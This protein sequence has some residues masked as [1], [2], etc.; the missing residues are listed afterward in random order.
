MALE[1][2]QD[3]QNAGQ[4]TQ[5]SDLVSAPDTTTM[6]I[7]NTA[8][9]DVLA[10]HA[11]M[12][13]EP[14]A[15]V[16]NYN[17]MKGE[18]AQNQGSTTYDNIMAAGNQYEDDASSRAMADILGDATVPLDQKVGYA[19][20]WK[21]GT[22]QP[23]GQDRKPSELVGINQLAKDSTV[24]DNAE[25]D[26]TRWDLA[27]YLKQV[28]DYNLEVNKIMN[29][30][31]LQ[32]NHGLV[33]KG[34]DLLESMVPFVS[35]A[36]QALIQTTLRKKLGQG[37]DANGLASGVAGS[38]TL[39]GESRQE[40][41]D[42]IAKLPYDKRLDMAKTVSDAVIAHNGSI[43]DD[44]NPMMAMNS[45][46]DYM[47]DGQYSTSD[48]VV[49][50]ATSLLDLLGV[51][52]VLRNLKRAPEL[53]SAAEA[54]RVTGRNPMTVGETVANTNA[55][56]ANEIIG[57]A[58][59]DTTGQV[60]KA[61]Y[62]TDRNSAIVNT[63]GPEIGNAQ[64]IVRQK[65]LIDDEHF[66]PDY[67]A[68]DT[69]LSNNGAIQFSDAEKQSKVAVVTNDF[70]NP[71]VTGLTN[72]KEMTTIK[73][74]DDGV[75]VRTVFAPDDGGFSNP[76]EALNQVKY[77]TRK[78]GVSDDELT[79]YKRDTD[80]Q[81]K[82]VDKSSIPQSDDI[83]TP[84]PVPKDHTRM[85]TGGS[86]K[87][88]D[89][90]LTY[91]TDLNKATTDAAAVDGGKVRYV[92]VPSSHPVFDNSTSTNQKGVELGADISYNRK[93]L[94]TGNYVVGVNHTTPFDPSDTINWSTTDV[95]GKFFGVP[96]NLFDK[97]PYY[98][99]G[100]GGSITQHL[101]PPQS[102]ID[103]LLARS[104]SVTSD[105]IAHSNNVL[106]HSANEY[107]TNYK[108][109]DRV[110]QKQIDNYILK[111][112]HDSIKF[113]PQQLKADGFSDDA[114]Q[115]LR[116]WKKT[117][118][119]Q[120]VLEN[121]DMG[122]QAK[123]KG[124]QMLQTV[125]GQDSLLV[126]PLSNST[127][128]N[129]GVTKAYDPELGVI[130]DIT[131][132]ERTELYKAG[133]NISMAR[134]PV[135]VKDQSI[136][137][138]IVKNNSSVYTRGLR[139]SD[140]L[141]NY[142]DG[143][144]TIYY[145]DPIFV[146]KIVKNADGSEYTR[147]VATV[148]N[149]KDA[150]SHLARLK[151]TDPEGKYDI[152]ADRV[153]EELNELLWNSRVNAGRTAQRTRGEMLEDVSGNPADVNFAH[154]A[155]PEESLLRSINSIS[156]RIN[157]KEW[158]DVTKK[159]FM[160]QYDDFIP[161]SADHAPIWPDDVT[162]LVKPNSITGDMRSYTDAVS[163]YRYVDQ[164]ENGFVNL[165]DDASKNLFKA[166]GDTVGK[167]GFK[168]MEGL[169]RGA[170]DI[171]PSAFLRKKAF[172]LLL[173]ANP[174]RQGVVQFSQAIPVI[175]ATNPTYFAK[176]P[177]QMLM[178]RYLDRGG[179][180]NSFMKTIGHSLAGFNED[181]ARQLTKAYQDSGI[182]SAV[183]AHSLIRDDLRSLVNR[184]PAA[185]IA[186]VAAKPIDVMQKVGF[187]AGENM[188]MR[189]VWLS[190]YDNLRKSGKAINNESLNLLHARVRD[191][192]LNMN[193]AGELAYNENMLSPIM[194][195]AQAPHK[196]FAQI[197]AGNRSL[198][199]MDRLK[200]GTSYVVTYGT[201]YGAIYSLSDS[202]LPRDDTDLHNIVSGGLANLALNKT[203]S[204][205]FGQKS[206]TDFSSS[207]RL[208]PLPNIGD[209]WTAM[210]T[211]DLQSMITGS[212]SLSMVVG[213]NGKVGNLLKSMYR[214]YTVPTD[215]G[216]LK[217]VG[218]N[219]LS[220]FSGASNMFKARYAFERGY[221]TTTKGQTSDP[222]VSEVE[223]MNMALG[224]NTTDDMLKY[225]LNDVQYAKSAQIRQ[226]AKYLIDE[227]AK[228]LGREGISDKEVEYVLRMYQEA[229]RVYS[230]SPA[231]LQVVQD[232][233]G[234]R[235]KNGDYTV[236]NSL[237]KNAGLYTEQEMRDAVGKSPL[238]EDQ[239]KGFWKIFDVMKAP[240]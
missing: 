51:G 124:F 171:K 45:L 140:K 221:S 165:L 61:V 217:D 191:L 9:A 39:L 112:N 151:T 216:A 163:T 10:S 14:Q 36:N 102:Y 103:P 145:K 27:P 181:E 40:I 83:A 109:L 156:K 119:T 187:E 198:S 220:M 15:A 43:G 60:A 86:P 92:D 7:N 193:K 23:V 78:Y 110:A 47:V 58:A 62:G 79:L 138:V 235:M 59:D 231:M 192:T 118:D 53:L 144:F 49:D 101:I 234:K 188:L 96:I 89:G 152:R 2:L 153:G 129:M 195:F 55:K 120:Y 74:V 80:G 98:T 64:D 236:L 176:L 160:N 183:S 223:A 63:I 31:E 107:A 88:S 132:K 87:L 5:L 210:A 42:L 208:L 70:T 128:G 71:D 205:I 209:M 29:S 117:Q 230:R 202:L 159:R 175:L 154:I 218:V 22:V 35:Q 104:A 91:T 194:Q 142:R 212:P 182:S 21:T 6:P 113:N 169:A 12:L 147:A 121:T 130:R 73:Q 200:L 41:R 3:L 157:M 172:R 222:N 30:Y 232:E 66:D 46:R 125:D 148:G 94:P 99:R 34:L 136:P 186:A 135:V 134:T 161:R 126:K 197:V 174:L 201:G 196:A 93:L 106:L 177:W 199:Q 203:L 28:N 214:F 211:M 57:K 90:A 226:D 75:N 170:E 224:F 146:T 167:K 54:A 37:D 206:N 122:R 162:Q 8:T 228:R 25:V 97:I 238:T 189:S 38:F 227:T 100:K 150:Q 139:D 1:N 67:K 115:T 178:T 65:P 116:S 233:I 149:I 44:K 84:P 219:F 143:H 141:L 237:I 13:T 114:I 105:K 111:A 17:T 207:M 16:D 166:I 239:K 240:E 52:A 179:D 48:R 133:G 50:D 81:Y 20:L 164:M 68:V 24:T 11:A 215:D 204:T 184:G 4:N 225:Q 123:R 180:V 155:T 229:N 77:A 131:S 33:D 108:A 190:E 32:N 213:D 137:Y 82:P 69:V 19:S 85:Y 185:K 168:T 76:Y 72:R 56:S 18:F 127:I 158:L 95:G 26:N 173:A